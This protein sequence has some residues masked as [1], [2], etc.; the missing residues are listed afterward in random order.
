MWTG[1]VKFSRNMFGILSDTDQMH[2][3]SVY[4][5]RPQNRISHA[6]NYVKAYIT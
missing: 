4:I 2:F 1:I 6:L 3:L 5:S